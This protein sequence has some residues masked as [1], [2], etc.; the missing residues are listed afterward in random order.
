MKKLIILTAFIVLGLCMS[1]QRFE[2][3]WAGEVSI[4]KIDG[5]TIAIPTEK[6][7]PKIKTSSSAGMILVGIGN[8]R[9]KVVIKNGRSTTQIKPDS[10]VT[11][12]IRCKENDTDPTTFIQ[13][14]K[15][16]E[17]KK[18]R[19]AELA[20]MNWLGNVTEGNMDYVN[21]TG[22]RYGKSS[23]ILTLQP[24]EG[25]YGVR[26]LNPNDKDEKVTVF[27]CFGIHDDDKK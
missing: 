19:K 10:V 9:S 20:N 3:E 17:K 7:I 13:V 14:V 23:Y 5:D 15:F 25:E 21:F 6:T 8:V 4:L 12:V 24:P 22:K 16:E 27:Y 18:E 2:P 1:A 11:L 26:V